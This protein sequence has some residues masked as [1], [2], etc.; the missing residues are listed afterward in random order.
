LTANWTSLLAEYSFSANAKV[1]WVAKDGDNYVLLKEGNFEQG[2]FTVNGMLSAQCDGLYA[3][4]IVY[5]EGQ[6][7][8]GIPGLN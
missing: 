6:Y 5:D 8:I 4:V 7:Y 2:T 3:G 1:L